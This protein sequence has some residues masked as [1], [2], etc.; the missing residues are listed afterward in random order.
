MPRDSLDAAAR[1]GESD[2]ID[3]MSAMMPQMRQLQQERDALQAK[4]KEQQSMISR[5]QSQNQELNS[6]FG[7][8]APTDQK[9]AKIVELAKKSR[10]LTLALDKEKAKSG[11][12][13]AELKRV[14]QELEA[15][16]RSKDAFVGMDA[17]SLPKE[18]KTSKDAKPGGTLAFGQKVPSDVNAENEL[19]PEDRVKELT[20]K[21]AAL[22]G[23]VNS[24]RLAN[25]RL[26]QE[27]GK[28]KE[29]LKRELGDVPVDT[30]L[31]ALDGGGAGAGWT[32]R[33]QTISL[34]QSK[35]VELKR[36][37]AVS[38]DAKLSP[39]GSPSANGA[40]PGAPLPPSPSKV[41]LD[42][43][44]KVDAQHRRE[45]DKIERERRQEAHALQ[46]VLDKERADK[47]ALKRKL[48]AAASRVSVLEKETRDLRDKM[49]VLLSKTDNDDQL[50][51]ALQ[52]EMATMAKAIKASS[53]SRK[54]EAKREDADE[55]SQL[56]LQEK[57]SQIQRQ[58]K[59]ILSLRAELQ[60]AVMR[61][62]E[63]ASRAD[64]VAG[65]E[66]A[67]DEVHL[68]RLTAAQHEVRMLQ[69]EK[70][71]LTE[72]TDVL[73]R[74]LAQAE[75]EVDGS[76][77]LIRQERQKSVDLERQLASSAQAHRTGRS[78]SAGSAASSRRAASANSFPPE[79]VQQLVD[80]LNST[81]EEMEALQQS[82][83]RTLSLKE[84]EVRAAKEQ[85]REQELLF[86][87]AQAELEEKL[88]HLQHLIQQA[89]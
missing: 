9:E 50:I 58:H 21:V 12:A 34:L 8:G 61:G 42:T 63:A 31:R 59:I 18:V 11:R 54:D 19:T 24:Q 74:K 81:T 45:I 22:N 37:L 41:Q 36:E 20:S 46:D 83:Q 28:V 33:A 26:K 85:L 62:K 78:G 48:D 39:G 64:R 79:K 6:S 68:T 43:A 32:G 69:V 65:M 84:H 23:Q 47:A 76:A 30:A 17:R 16:N 86:R 29:A 35:I 77:A 70:A 49:E 40:K 14:Q 57:S 38:L 51:E 2:S 25:E 75:E 1:G 87:E 5:L 60:A 7:D 72:L 82:F 13:T 66:R 27:N 71:K 73:K 88:G 53:R 55:Q 80:R 10:A 4:I 3:W 67:E 15:A 56:Q 44:S 89:R 52:T